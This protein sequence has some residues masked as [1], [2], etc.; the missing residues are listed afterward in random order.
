VFVRFASAAVGIATLFA[1][2]ATAQSAVK[3]H[4]ELWQPAGK[5]IKIYRQVKQSSCPA[6]AHHQAGKT[7][8][9]LGAVLAAKEACSA[10]VAAN[11]AKVRSASR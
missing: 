11:D 8:V 7:S 2:S 6:A 1:A 10:Q 3:T 4:E 5:T 9:P